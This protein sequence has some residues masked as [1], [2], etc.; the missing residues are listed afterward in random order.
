MNDDGGRR[1][2]RRPARACHDTQKGVRMI[3][4]DARAVADAVL[5]EGYAL[6]PYRPSSAKNQIRWQ[7]GVLAPRNW[8]ESGGGDPWWQETQTLIAPRDRRIQ[9]SGRLRFLQVQRRDSDADE[10][11]GRVAG[12]PTRRAVGAP[13]WRAVGGPTWDEGLLQEVDFALP[14]AGDNPARDD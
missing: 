7:F 10:P 9:V 13:T 3:F 2:L 5:F 6:Y 8:S 1:V 12:A 4:D 11:L 14:W